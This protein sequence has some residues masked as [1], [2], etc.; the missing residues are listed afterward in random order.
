VVVERRV[1]EGSNG[2]GDA[3]AAGLDGDVVVLLEVDTA[4][5]DVGVVGDTEK[6]ALN[7]GVGRARDVLAVLPLTV[8]RATGLLATV[9]RVA[10]GVSVEAIAA[11]GSESGSTAP[12]AAAA[13]TSAVT[14]SGAVEVT[15]HR[16]C[17][18]HGSGP[19]GAASSVRGNVGRADESTVAILSWGVLRLAQREV[20]HVELV[21]HVCDNG[22]RRLKSGRV[23]RCRLLGYGVG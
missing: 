21:G 10:I 4:V 17:T 23:M 3:L 8:T 22:F 9:T 1:G 20:A 11:S 13:A 16:R 19:S 2:L 12:A 18:I 7:T 6:L 15:V 5:L 14:G